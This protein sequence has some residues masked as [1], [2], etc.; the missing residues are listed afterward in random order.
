[1]KIDPKLNPRLYELRVEQE[2]L[3]DGFGRGLVQAAEKND[4]V[5][6]LC[7]DLSESTKVIDFAKKFPERFIELGVAEQNMASVAAGMAV[8]GKIP[9]ITSYAIF[10]PGRNWEQIRTNI[11]YNNVPVK[12]VG[13]HAGL[14]VGPDGGSHQM[15]EDLALTRVLPRLTVVAPADALEAE[16]ATLAAA[17]WDGPVYL[18]LAREK[19]PVLTT[20]DSPFKIG[21][22]KVLLRPAKP[23]MAIIACGL[24]VYRSLLAARKLE[25]EGI[26]ATVINNHTIK[27]L[28]EETLMDE[29][30]AAGAVVT[31][32]EH[33]QIGGLG[34]AVA[35]MLARRRPLPQE[36][37][38]V[39]DRFGQ[40]GTPAELMEH[41]GLGVDDIVE[42]VKRVIGRKRN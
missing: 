38:A 42:A 4:Q 22:A 35:E 32:E 29:A 27:P 20:E 39:A 15:L 30:V 19:S 12:I 18:R 25:R 31:A 33:Q 3:R 40:S 11:C 26:A 17:K 10:S 36:F 34:S 5:V 8:M 13:S 1:M 41:Y 9:F 14:N 37:V 16:R 7:A 28:D 21:E 23:D 24:M 6:A 2:A